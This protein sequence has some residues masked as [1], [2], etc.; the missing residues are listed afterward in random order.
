MN[1]YKVTKAF[2]LLDK[3]LL[4]PDDIVYAEE[5]RQMTH[6]YSPKTR[7]LLGRLSTEQF[8]TFV[9]LDRRRSPIK[10]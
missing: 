9:K 5:V 10:E 1:K 2:S 6:V 8:K 7:K 3:H 4:I